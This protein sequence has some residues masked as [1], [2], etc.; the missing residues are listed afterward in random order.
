M[1]I[2][3]LDSVAELIRERAQAISIYEAA[4][5]KG[6]SLCVD[7]AS[8]PGQDGVVS[9]FPC[10]PEQSF[11]SALI[12]IASDR[13][14]ELNR[15]LAGLGVNTPKFEKVEMSA[16]GWRWNCEMYLRAWIRELGGPSK[17]IGKTHLIDSLV[18]TTQKLREQARPKAKASAYTSPEEIAR[19]P[20]RDE[21]SGSGIKV[22]PKEAKTS[23]L[24]NIRG[25]I[26]AKLHEARSYAKQTGTAE[27]IIHPLDQLQA[28][29]LPLFPPDAVK[30]ERCNCDASCGE[31]RYHDLG[32]SGCRFGG[33]GKERFD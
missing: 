4:L 15:Q 26:L 6:S 11:R 21:T 9:V 28:I 8:L 16:A 32:D 17:L 1:K 31:N 29:L 5:D 27:L 13:I 12:E 14:V 7:L 33:A 24:V 10:L 19:K 25:L 23:A 2:D 3:Q 22:T 30:K 18:L 20:Y